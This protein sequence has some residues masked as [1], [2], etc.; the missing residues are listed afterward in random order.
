[1]FTPVPPSEDRPRGRESERDASAPPRW[2]LRRRRSEV[3]H[4]IWFALIV[5][6]AAALVLGILLGLL[7]YAAQPSPWE[8][9]DGQR[10]LPSRSTSMGLLV[11][12]T[13]LTLAP[14]LFLLCGLAASV[15][16]ILQ[17]MRR[18]ARAAARGPRRRRRLLDRRPHDYSSEVP[19]SEGPDVGR[20]P[21]E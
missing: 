8:N 14:A 19:E 5:G 11:L 9:W 3:A 15:R 4:I 20:G 6:G 12:N 13:T 16:V 10:F 21:R 17:G 2:L 18:S 7:L 1:M